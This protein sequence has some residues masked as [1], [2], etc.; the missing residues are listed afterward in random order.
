MKRL[1]VLTILLVPLLCHAATLKP[2]TVAG[3]DDYVHL[4]RSNLQD[5]M[6]TGGTF[7][8]ADENPDRV[9]RLHDGEIIVAPASA[10]TPRKIPGGLIHD[11]IGAAFLTNTKLDDILK[12]TRDYDRYKDFYRPFV[13]ESKTMGRNDPDDKFSMLLMNKMFFQKAALDADYQA[14]NVR[15]DSCRF[16]SVSEST[17]V[18]EIDGYGQPGERRIPEGEGAGYIWKLFSVARLEQRDGGVYME[19]ETAALSRDIPAMLHVLVDPIVRRVSHNALLL[20]IQQTEQAVRENSL[21]A[22][23][24]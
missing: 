22:E 24:H 17:R 20:S 7:L 4:V 18:Q 5:R 3:W 19:M 16:Y 12:V 9:A 21:V 2:E 13:M 15:L 11:W 6:R 23:S 8:W 10:Q 1:V 14:T